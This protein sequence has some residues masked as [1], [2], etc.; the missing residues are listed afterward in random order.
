M[1]EAHEAVIASAKT[2]LESVSSHQRTLLLAL[3]SKAAALKADA[4]HGQLG[5][6]SI[7]EALQRLSS[8]AAEMTQLTL[9]NGTDYNV[10]AATDQVLGLCPESRALEDLEVLP[11]S[12]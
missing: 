1:I 6:D 10:V 3:I 8:L 11:S 12:L 5:G 2:G 7:S 9:D 4:L